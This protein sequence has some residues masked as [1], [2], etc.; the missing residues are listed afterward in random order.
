[1]PRPIVSPKSSVGPSCARELQREA[2]ERASQTARDRAAPARY[3]PIRRE[4]SRAAITGAKLF[5]WRRRS[6]FSA[7][8][9]TDAMPSARARFPRAPR[10]RRT[11]RARA[12]SSSDRHVRRLPARSC[13]YTSW[14]CGDELREERVPRMAIAQLRQQL[15]R[16]LR[17]LLVPEIDEVQLVVGLVAKQRAVLA[18]AQHLL[19]PLGPVPARQQQQPP[20]ASWRP[21]ARRPRSSGRGRCR[22]TPPGA[23]DRARALVR[24]R[25]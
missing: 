6:S 20:Q 24:A 9:S 5:E 23:R 2:R 18:R 3:A 17:L 12:A 22:S 8:R 25:P 14:T 16:A 11:R 4:R 13:M 15:E 19:H 7:R 1:M 10:I 21:S